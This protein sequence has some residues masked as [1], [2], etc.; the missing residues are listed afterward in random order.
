MTTQY[1]TILKLAL[2]VQ[3]EL[4]GSWG[5]VVNDNITE[6]VEEAVA[7]L[8]TINSWTANSHTLTTANGTTSESRC[9]VLV[10]DDDGGGNPS[11]AATIICPAATKLYVLKNI[12]GQQVTLKTSGGTGVAVPNGSTA[13]LFCDGTNVEACQTDIIDATTIDTTNLEV[14]NIK[15]K[16]GTASGSIANSTGVF[17]IN[18]AVLTTADINGGTIDGT[19]IGGSSAAAGTFTTFTSTGID[20]NAS[21]TAIT[22]DSSQNVGIGVSTVDTALGTKLHVAGTIR[23]DTGA[24]G[25]N[26]AIVFDHDNFADADANYIMVDRTDE[27]MR[28]SVNASERMRITSSG[29]VGIGTS[30]PTAKVDIIETVASPTS[31]IWNGETLSLK[32]DTAYAEGVG[33]ALIFEGKYNSSGTYSTFGYIRGS[34][35]DA[36]DGGFR[37]G[38][39]YGTRNGD[40]VFVTNTSGL[41][42]GTDERMR[43]DSS[44]NVGIGNAAP[45]YLLDLYKAAS[46]VVRIRNSAATGGTPSATHGEFVIESTDAN[47]GMQFL[48]S[49]TADQRILFTDTAAVSGQIVYNHTSNYMA[50]FTNAGERMRIDSSGNVGI[51]TSSPS[52]TLHISTG[53]GNGIL[54]EDNNTSNI[55]PNLTIIGKRSDGN[56]SQCFGGKV[57]LAKNQTSAAIDAAENKLGTVMF[58]G[59]HTNSSISNILY[60]ASMSGISE[61]VFNSSTDMPTGLAFYTGST[62]QDGDTAAVTVGTERMRI[63]SS[64]NVGIGTTSPDRLFEV[65]EASGDAY[66]RLRA[67]DTG[68]G[69]DTIFENLCADNA[70][71]NY[72]YFG[73]LDDVDIGTIRYS[74]ASNFMSFTI[75]ASER[76]R[77]DSSGNVGIGTSSP[78]IPLDVQCNAAAIG[79]QLRGRSADD[80][81]VLRFRNNAADT[82]YFQ[83]DIRATGSYL[84]TVAN[85]PMLFFTNNTERM[86]IDSSGNVGIGVTTVDTA[87]GTKLHVAGAIRT[88]TGSANA[89]PTIVFDH[90]NFGDADANYIMLDR[91][92]EAMRFNVNAS[93]RMRIDSSGNVGIGV[94]PGAAKLQVSNSAATHTVLYLQQTNTSYNTDI[95]LY[96]AN[97]TTSSTLVSKRTSGDL[98]LYQSGANN[99]GVYTNAAERMRIESGGVV[100]PGADNTQSI[101]SASYRWSVVYAGT[102]T[103]NTSDEREKQ[104]IANLDD[105]ERRVAVAIKGLVKK[106]KYNDAVALKGDDARIHVGVIAQEVI[107]AFAAEG[108]D[109]TRYA[110]LCHDTWEAEPEEVDKNGNVINPGIE[111]GER[112]GIRYDELLAFMIAAL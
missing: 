67:S 106:Y 24:S 93:E 112:Y 73:D 89:N 54:L 87:L 100:R 98:W 109:A 83:L 78:F 59:N 36:T 8:A 85:I 20:D 86:R 27:A 37:G 13:F 45:S 76:M 14:T 51:G 81:S 48:G 31:S 66:I 111:A 82:T 33:G 42:D 58:G 72:I 84:N 60:A 70:Q 49:T 35:R 95:L 62:G 43:I 56:G 12:S 63:D 99:V 50:L 39:V 71:N 55:A 77:I 88:D 3:G 19:V 105:A 38:I 47:M 11:A 107:A 9:A 34:K 68:G 22:I 44:G 57:R 41:T 29:D 5:D 101:G 7:G 1:T 79:L 6:M 90:D 80:I 10:A 52:T 2:P 23:T 15:A 25:A 91:T 108:L 32:D 17:T 28:F 103:I 94:S 26:P 64:G 75:N 97:N 46:T 92:D 74:H 69:A 21:S 96:N 61:G 102:G 18:S 53:L 104:Q 65:D 40:H 110:L 4:S 16:D 30:S